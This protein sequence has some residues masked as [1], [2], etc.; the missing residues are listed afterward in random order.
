MEPLAP[1]FGGDKGSTWFSQ[2]RHPKSTPL[3]G[4]LLHICW[5]VR[6][7]ILLSGRMVT[8]LVGKWGL[9]FICPVEWSHIRWKCNVCLHLFV[10]LFVCL[11]YESGAEGGHQCAS[12]LALAP[13]DQDNERQRTA[14]IPGR[15]AM[16]L[17][18]HLS[19]WFMQGPWFPRFAENIAATVEFVLY[20]AKYIDL[21][22]QGTC[23]KL[24]NSFCIADI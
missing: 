10:C 15:V 18:T 3:S 8:Y 22:C 16:A 24:S 17:C 12:N 13:A 11:Q 5:N 4:I 14:Q 19:P 1:R 20:F 6:I 2:S 9:V 21:V 23:V 7:Y